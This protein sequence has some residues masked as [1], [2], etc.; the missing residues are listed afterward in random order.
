MAATNYSA[1]SSGEMDAT[2]M[3]RRNGNYR[4]IGPHIARQL[5]LT[6]VTL[7]HNPNQFRA[8]RSVTSRL[9]E[10][11]TFFTTPDKMRSV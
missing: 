2:V 8:Q 1:L 9:K 10:N 3:H 7:T 11:F 5:T 4:P 6:A